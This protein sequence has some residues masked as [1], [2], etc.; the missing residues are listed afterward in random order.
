M[1][2]LTAPQ[3]RRPHSFGALLLRLHFYAGVL[4]APFLIVAALTGLAYT[5]TPQLD[6]AA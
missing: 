4:V 2:T 5:L 3:G 1:L 6:Q